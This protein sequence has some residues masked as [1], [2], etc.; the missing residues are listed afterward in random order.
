MRIMHISTRLILGG[1][2]ENTVL[3]CE[4]LAARGYEVTLA[5]GPKP[6][7]S[8]KFAFTCPGSF[9]FCSCAIHMVTLFHINLRTFVP[10]K[11]QLPNHLPQPKH[12]IRF[13]VVPP[14]LLLS[15]HRAAH[16]QCTA[17]SGRS[18]LLRIGN[19]EPKKRVVRR[20]NGLGLA[21]N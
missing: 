11:S 19:P 20:G 16:R 6:F 3:S 18:Q 10:S 5:Y 14:T 15:I 12:K 13:L 1:A 4:G 9:V 7:V 21:A 8:C 2:Q 17:F